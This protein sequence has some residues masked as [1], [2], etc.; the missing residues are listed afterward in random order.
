MVLGFAFGFLREHVKIKKLE[1]K[2][3]RNRSNEDMVMKSVCKF[4]VRGLRL[5]R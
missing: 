2:F 1:G 4:C 3:G 5:I